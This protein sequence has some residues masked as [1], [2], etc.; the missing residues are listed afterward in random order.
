VNK[1]EILDIPAQFD[2]FSESFIK[3]PNTIKDADLIDK[4]VYKIY[5]KNMSV[6]DLFIN[7]SVQK[8][9]KTEDDTVLL[10]VKT[11]RNDDYKYPY[12]LDVKDYEEYIKSGPY[13]ITDTEKIIK[14]TESLSKGETDSY[15]LAKKLDRWVYKNITNKNLTV[16]FGN[17]IEVL[18]S[19]GGDCTEH[20]VL[21]A[22]LL[23]TANI[24]SKVV[25]G[26]VYTNTP[27]NGFVYHMWV[28]AYVGKWINLDPS[29]PYS[30]F[31]PLHI[32]MGESSLNELSDKNAL[33]MNVIKGFSNINIEIMDISKPA[34][35]PTKDKPIIYITTPD[36]NTITDYNI[37]KISASK[38][39]LTPSN[40]QQITVGDK[41]EKDP[42]RQAYYNYSIGKFDDALSELE[43]YHGNIEE[44]DDFSRMKL[45]LKSLNMGF[46][47]FA[48]KVIKEIED[49]E[50]WGNYINYLIK[51]NFP[52][53]KMPSDVEM[54]AVNALNYLNFKDDTESV[55]DITM[56]LQ[57]FDY[58]NYLR[59]K[60]FRKNKNLKE[61][62]NSI[63]K[64]IKT[65]PAS[66]GYRMELANIFS[67]QNDIVKAQE[68]LKYINLIAKKNVV[69]D[70]E[71]WKQ[72]KMID[73]WLKAKQNEK[74]NYLLGKYYEA[75]YYLTK[76]EF[77]QAEEVTVYALNYKK[78]AYLYELLG[79]IY[80]AVDRFKGAKFWYEKALNLD[81][82]R[83]RA[84]IGLGNVYFS[85]EENL[86]SNKYYNDALKLSPYNIEALLALGKLNAYLGYKKKSYEYY[87]RVLT[88]NKNNPEV[89]YILGIELAYSGNYKEGKRL[90]K[91]SLSANPMASLIWADLARIEINEKN[92]PKAFLYLTTLKNINENNPYYY[93]L[94]AL[95]LK[96]TD[97]MAEA[98]KYLKKAL[99]LKPDLINEIIPKKEELKEFH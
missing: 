71:F 97:K 29:F 84:N 27:Q 96:E 6:K 63:L 65:A 12:P 72:Y 74:N 75:F 31:T 38:Q 9:I 66:L 91:K 68:Q 49:K 8:I 85:E 61:A 93:Y 94:S 35:I 42:I 95:I 82:K 3:V 23:R 83:I 86:K 37:L 99:E 69:K 15:K 77:N 4:A 11:E 53:L 10:S 32:A 36:E 44:G 62:Q 39:Q 70:Q 26:L 33:V 19:K 41:V 81:P 25:V 56:T 76:G 17:A 98:E 79:D 16:D 28:K 55:L 2:I 18:E 7:D 78:T 47:D 52:T 59:A 60:A 67:D 21:L 90:L 89:L 34:V 64:A 14:L 87:K 51:M 20:S 88:I 30:N 24:P 45:A 80:Y 22:S 13:I 46:F 40:I 92:Y 48:S 73:F 1:T 57:D 54:V 58:I 50:I 5:L 43:T